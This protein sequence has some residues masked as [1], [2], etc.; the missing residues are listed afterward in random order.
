MFEITDEPAV[1][2]KKAREIRKNIIKMLQAA[3]SGHTA[4]SLGMADV[5]ATL[6]F[7]VL[8]HDSI[9][10]DDEKRDKV[11]LSNG[12][13]CPV[14]YATLAECGYFEKEKLLSLRKMGSPLQGHPHMGALPGIENSS[15]P[16]AQGTSIACG[17]AIANKLD[18][19][20]GIIYLLSSD[21]EHQEG[22]TW[23]AAMLA[24]KYKLGN[25]IQIMDRN[26]IQI[27]G[28]TDDVMPLEPLAEKYLS[29]GW[30]VI[31]L[32]GHDVER[33]YGVLDE[34]SKKARELKEGKPT[35]IIANTVPGKGVGF[36]E[37]GGYKWHGKAPNAQEAQKALQELDKE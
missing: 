19:N 24:S 31:V 36:I 1:F 35:V 26:N 32:D 14:L 22:Q 5:F 34:L 3:G 20:D 29:F 2:Q 23:E 6:Y 30:D 11:I 10:S 12:H 27:D 33:L 13:I 17:M 21:G 4:G 28:K 18:N 9:N 7:G 15:G 8:R 16:L 37:E 25:L